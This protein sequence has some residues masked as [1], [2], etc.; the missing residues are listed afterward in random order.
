MQLKHL[1]VQIER[2][3]GGYLSPGVSILVA[4]NTSIF[5][6]ALFTGSASS[7]ALS[8][9][10]QAFVA[11]RSILEGQLWRL[12]TAAVTHEMVMHWFWN[13]VGLFFF[14]NHIERHFGTRG[15]F[16]LAAIVA[17]IGNGFH[18]AVMGTPVLGFSGVV[19]AII[20]GFAA[21][22]PTARVIMLVIPMPAWVLA[23]L[24]VG[25]DTLNFI[26]QGSRSYIAYDVHL[27]GAA[28]GLVAVRGGRM[29]RWLPQA[30]QRRRLRRQAQQQV[31]DQSELD[32]L[33]AK[34]SEQGIPSLTKAER[35]FLERYSK[36]HRSP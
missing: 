25:L 32:R 16:I 11:D 21:I 2:S 7:G 30:W 20:V 18:I 17:V 5:L 10:A 34:V 13:M 28:I 36:R 4:I 1:L 31:F 9:I 14:G 15:L 27:I 23:A 29:W 26:Q 3:T 35:S 12:F 22:A 8:P 6:I 19:Y 24:F 33:L